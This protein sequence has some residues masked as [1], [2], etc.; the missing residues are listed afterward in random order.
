MF[1]SYSRALPKNISTR[2]LQRL[3]SETYDRNWYGTGRGSDRVI[4]RVTRLLPQAV[5]YRVKLL[6]GKPVI[7]EK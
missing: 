4:V 2:K 3:S 5:P 6:L 7:R 1:V